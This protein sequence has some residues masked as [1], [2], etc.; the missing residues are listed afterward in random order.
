MAKHKKKGCKGIPVEKKKKEQLNQQ[1]EGDQIEQGILGK[2]SK[3]N[4]VDVQTI[5]K[6]KEIQG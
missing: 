6:E 3:P 2:R 5:K 4:I 1:T